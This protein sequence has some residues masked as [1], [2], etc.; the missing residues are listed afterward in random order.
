[1]KTISPVCDEKEWT[2]YVGVVMKSEIRGIELVARMVTR[3]DVDNE[4]AWSS[5]LPEAVDEQHVECGVVLTQPSQETQADTDPE[6]P[7]FFCSNK[8]ILNE[9]PVCGSVGVGDAAAADTMFILGVDP[10]SIA[11]ASCS[12]NRVPIALVPCIDKGCQ[13]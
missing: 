7:S 11:L 4:S 2:T 8:T 6:E 10:Q 1:M 9:E 3:N 13:G 5:I 12:D